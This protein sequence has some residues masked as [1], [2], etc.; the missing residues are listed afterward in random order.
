MITTFIKRALGVWL[1]VLLPALSYAGVPSGH[2]ES[3]FDRQHGV[4]DVTGSYN[5]TEL[6][7][8]DQYTIVQ[9]DKGKINGQGRMTGT[10]GGIY[11]ELATTYSGSIKSIGDITRVV[12]K[13]RLAGTATDGYQAATVKGKITYT[14]DID[15]LSNRLVGTAKGKVCA[16]GPGGSE[17]AP[18]NEAAQADLPEEAQGTWDLVLDIQS[19]E[20]KKLT[21]TASAILSNGRTEP[22]A[23]KGKYD[24]QTDLTKL[25][26]K[27]SGGKLT[28]QAQEVLGQL[29]FQSIKGKLLGQTVNQ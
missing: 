19:A 11:I 5:E 6:G 26:L 10:D 25:G 1:L 24:A 2:Y 20:G 21:G 15:K 27:G 18:F 14:Y 13:E 17:C 29:V 7:I 4:W 28:I 8:S 23:L 16:K 22:L 3:H 9:D 12:L